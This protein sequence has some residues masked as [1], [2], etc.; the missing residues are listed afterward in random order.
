MFMRVKEL[1]LVEGVFVPSHDAVNAFDEDTQGEVHLP[2]PHGQHLVES[3]QEHGSL[4]HDVDE[5]VEEAVAEDVDLILENRDDSSDRSDVE[6]QVHGCGEQWLE[7]LQ[8]E[9]V[10]G[11][12]HDPLL[13]VLSRD[14]RS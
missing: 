5:E 3:D 1:D 6:E 2:G 13:Q 8:E 10:G 14:D 11:S 4:V 9:G 12:S 7:C